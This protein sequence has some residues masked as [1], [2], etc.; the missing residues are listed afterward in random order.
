MFLRRFAIGL[1]ALSLV[2]QPVVAQSVRLQPSLELSTGDA[3]GSGGV[4]RDR[5]LDGGA[6]LAVGLRVVRPQSFGMFVEVAGDALDVAADH[7]TNCPPSPRGGC[8]HWYP[9]FVGVSGVVGVIGQPSSEWEWRT[10]IGG[11][12]Y[13]A[14]GTKVGAVVSQA[15][16]AVFPFAYVGMFAGVRAIVMPSFRHDR[17][18]MIPWMI[19]VRV[20]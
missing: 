5:H 16:I 7:L 3:F 14:D 11:G 4:Y 1:I 12:A 9:A 6:R 15:D 18:W 8:L 19:G 10:A 13:G 20:R 17:L 2:G